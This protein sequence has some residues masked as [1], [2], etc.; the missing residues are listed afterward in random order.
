MVR[1]KVLG[2]VRSRCGVHRRHIEGCI[3]TAIDR[4]DKVTPRISKKAA[5]DKNM[6]V[7][8]QKS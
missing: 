2:T 8:N 7:R 5:Q 6:V 4:A 1:V 3:D